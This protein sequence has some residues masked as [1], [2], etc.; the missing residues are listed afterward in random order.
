VHSIKGGSDIFDLAKIGELAHQTENV[1][2]LIRSRKMAPTPDRVRVLL[3]ATDRLSQLLKEAAT[4]NQA[5]IA[6]LSAELA[7]LYADHRT[8][9]QKSG[10]PAQ[11]PA[12]QG[13]ATLRV[14]LTEDD[15]ACRL[16]MQTFLSRYGECH[17]AANGKEAVDAVRAAINQ[18]QKYDL[19]C[20]DIMMPEM[21][22][23][24]AVRQ[25]R[26]LEETFGI[27]STSGA[28]IIMTTAVD[29]V[30]EVIRCF[31]ELCD[32]YLV[33][34]IDLNQLVGHMRSFRLVP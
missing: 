28:K 31:K 22:G 7:K 5:D 21:N 6:D 15:F 10:A 20:M 2:A 33:K 18:G 8:P 19:I 11:K 24:E 1:L 25:V 9:V 26:E 29:E 13:T 3:N 17:I 27:L 12:I 16:L 4:S 14:L 23:R 32:A 30:K 34:P